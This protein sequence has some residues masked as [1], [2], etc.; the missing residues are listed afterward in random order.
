RRLLFR[1]GINIGD[2]IVDGDDIHG[3]G[4]NVAARLEA[5]AEPG[6]ILVSGDAYNQLKAR[7]PLGFDDQG[8]K[9]L[10]NIPEPVR[11][12]RVKLEEAEAAP[13]SPNLAAMRAKP[14][15]IAGAAPAAV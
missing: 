13:P 7:L 12:L 9:A 6:G 14:A 3:D 5:L 11:V 2:L 10:K 1:M 8:L 4:V 15:L